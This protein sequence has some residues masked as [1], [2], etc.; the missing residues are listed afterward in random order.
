MIKDSEAG[1]VKKVVKNIYE[2]YKNVV[3]KEDAKVVVIGPSISVFTDPTLLLTAHLIGKKGNLFVVDPQTQEKPTGNETTI[4]KILQ[5]SGNINNHLK[6]IDLF[7][8]IG[9]DLMSPKWLGKESD[10]K[11]IEL[12]DNSIDVIVDHSTSIFLAELNTY[13]DFSLN[14]VSTRNE[15]LKSCFAEYQRILKNEGCLLLQANAENY[16]LR[17]TEM[18]IGKQTLSDLLQSNNFEFNYIKINDVLK[19]PINDVTLDILKE[20]IDMDKWGTFNGR[21]L[22][23][24]KIRIVQSQNKNFIQFHDSSPDLFV[25]KKKTTK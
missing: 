4:D 16:C 2:E 7:K 20:N 1:E 21:D 24:L 12:P 14:F 18:G 15:Y 11:N 8:K 22:H 3:S 5:N 25:A 6:Q 13:K 23:E 9:M 10:I 19:I 17:K